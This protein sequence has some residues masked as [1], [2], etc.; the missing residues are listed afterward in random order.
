MPSEPLALEMLRAIRASST[1]LNRSQ[2][3]VIEKMKYGSALM[4]RTYLLE[5]LHIIF[6]VGVD[7]GLKSTFN[8]G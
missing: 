4:L 6:V 7:L 3:N 1:L 2:C 5:S 8:L